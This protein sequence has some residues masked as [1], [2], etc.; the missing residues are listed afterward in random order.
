MLLSTRSSGLGLLPVCGGGLTS[1][2]GASYLG[3]GLILLLV[4]F[5]NLKF[6]SKYCG[7]KDLDEVFS[8]LWLIIKPFLPKSVILRQ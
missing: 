4:H 1:E 5:L 2:L 3:S 8:Q 6:S 7:I